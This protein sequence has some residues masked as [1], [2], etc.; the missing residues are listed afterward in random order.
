LFNFQWCFLF[1]YTGVTSC[2]GDTHNVLCDI[3]NTNK[4]YTVSSHPT[5]FT[6]ADFTVIILHNWVE[7]AHPQ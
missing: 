1:V 5:I 6:A 3:T 7:V 4:C 2:D